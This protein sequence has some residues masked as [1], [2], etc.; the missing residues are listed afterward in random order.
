[1]RR[2]HDPGPIGPWY[3]KMNWAA[4]GQQRRFATTTTKGPYNVLR[5]GIGVV[6][7][8]PHPMG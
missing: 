3:R 2:L 8:V 1:L 4:R 7:V 5:E 6:A